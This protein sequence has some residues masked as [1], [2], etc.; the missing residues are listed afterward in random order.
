MNEHE[1]GFI[2]FLAPPSGRRFR[3]LLELGAKRRNDLRA[4]LDHGLNLDP[5]SAFPLEGRS[6]SAPAIEDALFARGAPSICRVTSADRVLDGR[7]MPLRGAINAISGTSFGS[8]ISCIPG[9]LGYFEY[10]DLRS[11][12]LLCR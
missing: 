7:E 2:A 6:A 12:Y 9:K 3:T 8:F 5:H 1:L 4:L 10:E 11:A